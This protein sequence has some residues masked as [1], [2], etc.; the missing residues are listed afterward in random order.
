MKIAV[1]HETSAAGSSYDN[2]SH[3]NKRQLQKR[4]SN[5]RE[6]EKG[7][8]RKRDNTTTTT[9]STRRDRRWEIDGRLSMGRREETRMRGLAP[10]PTL[11]VEG[12]KGRERDAGYSVDHQDPHPHGG[13]SCAGVAT[14]V[15]DRQ[16][17]VRGVGVL[18]KAG[19]RGGELSSSN[20]SVSVTSYQAHDRCTRRR[21]SA[22][23]IRGMHTRSY[24]C[25]GTDERK[26]W[27]NV[28]RLGGVLPSEREREREDYNKEAKTKK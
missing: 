21:R 15:G 9:K 17:N 2:E 20:R 6:W 23:C 25:Y 7:R 5:A 3:L 11:A 12:E 16:G 1:W 24:F 19:A 26:C 28:R 18:Y 22:S 10:S 8:R 27:R 13:V 4:S 14:T